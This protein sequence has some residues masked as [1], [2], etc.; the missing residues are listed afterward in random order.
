[1]FRPSEEVDIKTICRA[2]NA[3]YRALQ[4]HCTGV[5]QLPPDTIKFMTERLLEQ[6]LILEEAAKEVYN[7]LPDDIKQLLDKQEQQRNNSVYF[8]SRGNPL[9]N[10][11]H[12]AIQTCIDNAQ[13]RY[14]SIR[15]KA[16]QRVNT[17]DSAQI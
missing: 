11:D 16:E 9:K 4:A 2:A 13:A 8:D 12:A 10:C 6:V 14:D 15:E 1:M 7:E 17:P 3:Y 5:I